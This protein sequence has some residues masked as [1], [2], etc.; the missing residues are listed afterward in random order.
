MPE[1]LTATEAP[2]TI[3]IPPFRPGEEA[4]FGE[5]FVEQP[6][7]LNRPEVN[8]SAQD[9]ATHAVGLIRVL[10]DEHVA[11][12]EWNP[13]LDEETLLK[14]L[15]HMMRLRI[16]DDRMM[17]MQRTGL[18][19]FYMRSF[20]EEAI[21]IAQTMALEE[22]DWLFPSYRQPGAQFVRGRDM[23]SMICHCIGNTEDNV[24]GRQM[25]VHYTWKEGR[26]ISISSPVGTQFPQAVGVAMASAYRGLDEVCISWL[27]DGT[28]AQGDFHYAV[29]FASTFKPPVIL[30]VVNNQWA[31]STHANLA[32]G[33][34]TFA[35]RGLAYDIPSFR[36]DGND[37]LALYAVTKWARDRAGAGLGPTFIEVYTYRAGAHSSSDDPIAYRPQ[38]EFKHWPGGDPIERLKGHLIGRGL[39]DEDKHTALTERI[40]AEVMAAYKEA[41]TFGDLANGPYPPASTIFTEVY[42]EVPWHVQEQREE[43]GK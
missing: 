30:N 43:L 16:F 42:E 14:G 36:V 13:N 21:A 27:G 32:T 9:T 19:S 28:S 6:G 29:N 35:E 22:Q 39:W 2:Y 5:G 40:D 24:R 34:R 33:G 18:L 26:F 20:G 25:P 3:G 7:D 8:C 11:H 12:G 17:K 31:I 10:D 15:E 41:C 38:D 4:D 1:R 23:V 37:F